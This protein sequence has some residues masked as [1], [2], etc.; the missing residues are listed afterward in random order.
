MQLGLAQ[1]W[2]SKA[3]RLPRNDA[4]WLAADILATALR[5]QGNYAEAEALSRK[6]L[7]GLRHQ[8]THEHVGRCSQHGQDT[9]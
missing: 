7:E 5:D 2:W 3:R 1:T 9:R 4:E 6:S 8:T